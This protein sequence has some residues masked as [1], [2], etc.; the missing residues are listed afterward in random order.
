MRSMS[1]SVPTPIGRFVSKGGATM[2]RA[3]YR[4][5]RR[6]KGAGLLVRRRRRV[7]R[8]C[9]G[10]AL[11]GAL[12]ADVSRR[13]FRFGLVRLGDS[14]QWGGGLHDFY[15]FS[16]ADAPDL[17]ISGDGTVKASLP[18]VQECRDGLLDPAL[19]YLG[20]C[21]RGNLARVFGRDVAFPAGR[22][23]ARHLVRGVRGDRGAADRGAFDAGRRET[24]GDVRLRS[25]S[26][27][28]RQG[29]R[30]I[31]CRGRADVGRSDGT[32]A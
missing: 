7:G 15:A 19:L 30:W 22:D 13:I 16:P 2:P 10:Y 25:R 29:R 26:R 21:R 3:L 5:S 14:Q 23:V 4:R 24:G 17:E 1:I 28:S 18:S 9:A 20:F 11:R 31:E 8:L 6:R 12:C 32:P 27:P